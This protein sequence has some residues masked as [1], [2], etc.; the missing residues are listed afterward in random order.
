MKKAEI[1]SDNLLRTR[2]KL[3]GDMLG[4]VVREQSGEEVFDAVEKLRYGFS[5]LRKNHKE[6]LHDELIGFIAE[7]D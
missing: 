5:E 6:D 1:H 2:V 7:M 3:L 4:R